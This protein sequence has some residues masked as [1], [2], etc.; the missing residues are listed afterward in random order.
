MDGG[1]GGEVLPDQHQG[2]GEPGEKCRGQRHGPGLAD[3]LQVV[4][5]KGH[6]KGEDGRGQ[7]ADG[8]GK[9]VQEQIADPRPDEGGPAA[10]P[11]PCGPHQGH[12]KGA[13]VV[14]DHR[15]RQHCGQ[16]KVDARL[17]AQGQGRSGQFDLSRGPGLMAQLEKSCFD[18]LSGSH[19]GSSFV[20][21]GDRPPICDCHYIPVNGK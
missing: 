12:R 17:Q 6:R 10:E 18:A 2:P 14:Q 3:R 20:Q 11:R 7:V 13:A 9:G 4:E 15:P 1:R 16:Q 5:R 21:P 8:L 19:A